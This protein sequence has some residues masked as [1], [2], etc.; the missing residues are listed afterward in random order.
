MVVVLDL[1]R[2]VYL[3]T[4]YNFC[5]RNMKDFLKFSHFDLFLESLTVILIR[6]SKKDS[7]WEL[8]KACSGGLEES[9]QCLGQ[10]T[11]KQSLIFKKGA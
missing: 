11:G 10:A 1:S 7:Q 4:E 2:N 6:K 3:V 8:S 9:A 5:L